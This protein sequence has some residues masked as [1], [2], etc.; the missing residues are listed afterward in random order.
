MTRPRWNLRWIGLGVAVLLVVL[1]A[2]GGGMALRNNNAA[3]HTERQSEAEGDHPTEG[4]GGG[5]AKRREA[6][7][8]GVESS[9]HD[10]N[11]GY[12]GWFYGQRSAPGKHVPSGA[13]AAASAATQAIRADG[14]VAQSSAVW[15]NL[16]P[17]PTNQDASKYH[18]PVWSNYGGGIGRATGRVAAMAVDPTDANVVYEGAADGGVWKSTDGGTSWTLISQALGTQS[19]GAIAIP[20]GA[21]NTI[22]VGTGESNTNQDSYFGDG[23]YRSSNGGR[24]WGRSAARRSTA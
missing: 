24:T 11:A 2:V 23:I 10:P 16:G 1:A 3:S 13:L 21:H 7:S 14:K 6:T 4:D 15:Q 8:H 12:A 5:R 22:Y 18:D 17:A 9:V 20:P 19:I